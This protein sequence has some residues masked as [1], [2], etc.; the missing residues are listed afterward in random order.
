MPPLFAYGSLILPTSL[1]SRF[2]DFDTSI[3]DVYRGNTNGNI[4]G[5][6]LKEWQNRKDRIYYVPAKIWG[7]RRYYSLESPRGGTMLEVVR[8]N[9][10]N[11]WINGVLIFGLSEEEEVQVKKTESVYEFADVRDPKLEFYVDDVPNVDLADVDRIQ[12]FSK[13]YEIDKISTKRTRN[14]TYHSRIITGIKMVDEM[15]DTDFAKQFY[16]DFRESTFETAYDS[17]DPRE[18]NTVKEN[19]RLKGDPDWPVRGL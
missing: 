19:D 12:L 16:D 5:D 10:S 17:E 11:D 14:E 4:S 6:A 3:D 2:E 15:Y 18:F 8:T 7:F 13:S 9:D 1:V